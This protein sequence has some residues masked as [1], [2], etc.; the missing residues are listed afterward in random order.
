VEAPRIDISSSYIRQKIKEQKSIK[1]L[2][3]TEVE[4]YIIEN[5]LYMNY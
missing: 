3:T 1:Y 5:K 4:K 2:V